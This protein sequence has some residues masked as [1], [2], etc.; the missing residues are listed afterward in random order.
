MYYRNVT[1][2]GLA[3][4]ADRAGINHE[5]L[6]SLRFHDLRHT[7]ASLLIAQGLNVF[8]VSR[9]L[10]HALTRTTL[11]VYTGLFMRA[12]HANHAV[13]G[14]EAVFPSSLWG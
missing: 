4:A 5:P 10:G 3:F 8:F 1:R 6:P 2:Q 13:E 14:L 7:Y 12:E 9:Q 11:D